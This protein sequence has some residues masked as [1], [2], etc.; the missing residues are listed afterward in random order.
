[1][2]T[3][4]IT[5]NHQSYEVKVDLSTTLLEVLREKLSITSPKVGCN[6]GDCRGLTGVSMVQ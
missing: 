3:L 2:Q 1:M 6:S 5:V 4:R